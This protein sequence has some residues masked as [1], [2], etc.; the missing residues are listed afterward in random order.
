REGCRRRDPTGERGYRGRQC[1]VEWRWHGLL[2]H[3]IPP[4]GRAAASR[5]ELLSTGVLSPHRNGY[6]TRRVCSGQ[7]LSA[8]RRNSTSV[9]GWAKVC[10]GADGERG[11][12]RLPGL[13]ARGG[14]TLVSGAPALGPLL[15]GRVRAGQFAVPAFAKGRTPRPVIGDDWTFLCGR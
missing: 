5:H 7:E 1:G 4:R 12:R 8:D 15:G 2:V 11:G 14:G 10:A 6:R 3:A 13:P 9:I